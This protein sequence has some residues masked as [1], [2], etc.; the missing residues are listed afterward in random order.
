MVR[1]KC[2]SFCWSSHLLCLMVLVIG[3]SLARFLPFAP[4][5]FESRWTPFAHCRPEVLRAFCAFTHEPQRH[6]DMRNIRPVFQGLFSHGFIVF[7]FYRSF[8]S[9]LMAVASY[10]HLQYSPSHIPVISK[11]RLVL[12]AGSLDPRHPIASNTL[13]RP[14]PRKRIDVIGKFRFSAR[15]L[16]V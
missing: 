3:I 5:L 10:S 16:L 9:S 7:R 2:H 12:R 8:T 14:R 1:L 13:V 11:H 4:F 15:V 6:P